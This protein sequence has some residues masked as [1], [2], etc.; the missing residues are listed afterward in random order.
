MAISVEKHMGQDGKRF[1]LEA[2]KHEETTYRTTVKSTFE[3]NRSMT[4]IMS[5]I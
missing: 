1:S 2:I 5:S 4:E 3:I